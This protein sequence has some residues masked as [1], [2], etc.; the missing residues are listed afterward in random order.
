MESVKC[1]VFSGEETFT[2]PRHWVKKN[3]QVSEKS[4]KGNGKVPQFLQEDWSPLGL[5]QL[6]F[7]TEIMQMMADYT[8]TY[9]QQKGAHTFSVTS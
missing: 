5:F 3:L 9:A 2:Q 4:D 6:L 8:M 7:D 1:I